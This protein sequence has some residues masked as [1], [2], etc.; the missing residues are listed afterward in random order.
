MMTLLTM[1]LLPTGPESLKISKLS[2][3]FYLTLEMLGGQDSSGL[4]GH[5]G[6]FHPPNPLQRVDI[7]ILSKMV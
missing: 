4:L 1:T 2:G 3:C 7:R 5:D 6:Y